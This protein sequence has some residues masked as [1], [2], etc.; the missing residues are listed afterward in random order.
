MRPY[1]GHAGIPERHVEIV[2]VCWKYDRFV[3]T[4]L[5]RWRRLVVGRLQRQERTAMVRV[6]QHQRL[7]PGEMF[8]RR[9]L[10]Q[11]RV[12]ER[13]QVQQPVQPFG[14]QMLEHVFPHV[15]VNRSIRILGSFFLN[16]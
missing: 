11:V 1:V 10:P 8:G 7:D 4:G 16:P 12:V 9:E 2:F 5:R 13:F 14:G 3:E 15:P 6:G